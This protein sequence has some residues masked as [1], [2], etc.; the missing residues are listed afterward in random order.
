MNLDALIAP[1]TY[2][3]LALLI[4]TSLALI[5][6]VLSIAGRPHSIF[7]GLS[8]FYICSCLFFLG[9]Y[10][11]PLQ[12]N[13]WAIFFWH[14]VM[15]LGLS[16]MPVGWVWL[17]HDLAGKKPTAILWINVA[18]AGILTVILFTV[19]HPAVTGPPLTYV[20][21]VGSYRPRSYIFRPLTFAFS[22]G[23]ILISLYLLTVKWR[24]E[25]SSP[26]ITRPIIISIGLLFVVGTHD[27]L[28][29]VGLI[30]PL[31]GLLLSWSGS[32]L[33]SFSLVIAV[34]A[35]LRGIEQ[36]LIDN[37]N[38]LRVLVES[39]HDPILSMSTDRTILE[40]NP[41]IENLLGYTDE[42]LKGQSPRLL[43]ISEDKFL[44]FGRMVYSRVIERGSWRGR[45]PYRHKTGRAVISDTVVSAIKDESGRITGYL[46]IHRDQT[47]QIE[48][49]RRLKRQNRYL[50]ALH[51]ATVGLMEKT[52][53]DSLL[54]SVV[55][56]AAEL[57]HTPHSWIV[58]LNQTG[59]RLVSRYGVGIY[60]KLIGVEVKKGEAISGM[61][62]ERNGPVVADSFSDYPKHIMDQLEGLS[63]MAGL[64]LFSGEDF[65]G[66]LGVA[67][68][69]G[70][71]RF[72]EEEVELLTR[73]AQ[74]ASIIQG[75]AQSYSLLSQELNERKKAEE[76]LR[77]S[78]QR[79]R[80]LFDSVSDLIYTQDLEGRFITLNQAIAASFGYPREYFVGK[81]PR[82]FMRPDERKL[83]QTEYLD[84]LIKGG[85]FQGITP[86]FNRD[87]EQIFIEYK[88]VLVHPREGAP[89]ISGV[90]RDVTERIL[91]SR[92]LKGLQAQLA[93]AQKLEAVGTLAGG[94]AHD[95]NNIL[96]AFSG[97]LDLV[98]TEIA[99]N[100]RLGTHLQETRRILDRAAGLVRR[101][102]T[103]SRKE[104]TNLVPV[105][106][107]QE[108][109]ATV[110]ILERVIPRM[111]K[112]TTDL[113]PDLALIKGDPSQLEQILM[114][115]GTNAKDAMPE[116][117]SL[118]IRTRNITL[119][120]DSAEQYLEGKAGD[121]V[122]LTV[123]DSGQGMDP[124]IMNHMYE[125]FFTTKGVGQGTGLGLSSIY[126]IIKE[127]NGYILCESAPG[128]G[129][130]FKIYLPELKGEHKAAATEDHDP[131]AAAGG[132]ETILVVDDEEA[133]RSLSRDLLS[134]HGF[135]V[136]LASSG[137]EALET[138]ERLADEID[139]VVLDLGM[140][141]MG[142][143]KC[144]EKLLVLDPE[145]RVI[146][147]SGYNDQGQIHQIEQAGA[148]G[149]LA[150]P[151]RLS[152][153]LTKV[154]EVL[155]AP[156]EEFS[157][158]P[159]R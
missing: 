97:Y 152:N 124:Q 149:F 39:S 16:W 127:Y 51:R 62:W 139:L 145:V 158:N 52:D 125:P 126:G 31:F 136:H 95:F 92:K 144:L 4:N 77:E 133:V 3:L 85:E 112:I 89:Y 20:D 63:V 118:L 75:N 58:T 138:Y 82:D 114:N 102:M 74:L 121:Y 48:A 26:L 87:G 32:I 131:A 134:F 66:V 146:V 116:G 142:G 156:G 99:N 83:F 10:L 34:T 123:T 64:P 79:Y 19:N 46:A 18:L 111:I 44:E 140:P 41:A 71:P 38:R 90:G 148:R 59:D 11:Y 103:F 86:Y 154:R 60:E 43:H 153:L 35:Y 29:A 130:T 47:E 104:K 147:A 157:Q 84:R 30:N 2:N 109:T 96:Q 81:S 107:N 119:D 15:L 117:G 54:L 17:A 69:A 14:R 98:E 23:S 9:L 36:R 113:D 80:D 13:S 106:L 27:A 28:A 155:D 78:E 129:T 55:S 6:L 108:I 120:Q 33:F 115:L 45:W 61:V 12:N 88:S 159:A 151:Y 72:S 91:A 5:S 137:E 50:E 57:M 67:R 94:V 110:K 40:C 25:V 143:F 49:E 68:E 42:E 7:R 105:Q 70:E 22:L 122:E 37:E 73:L 56:S 76:A 101:L 141:G 132:T 93:Q 150:K 24:G 21:L 100:P 128:R 53:P 135:K 65:I 1:G 8:G